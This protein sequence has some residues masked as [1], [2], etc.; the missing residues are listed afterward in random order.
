MTNISDDQGAGDPYFLN[1][2]TVIEMVDGHVFYAFFCFSADEQVVLF[3]TTD[4]KKPAIV[5]I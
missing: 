3:F 2:D 4:L 5:I 1:S